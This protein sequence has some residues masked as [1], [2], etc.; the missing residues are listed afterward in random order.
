MFN[1]CDYVTQVGQGPHSVEHDS[2]LG[3][4][5]AEPV[6]LR[7]LYLRDLEALSDG[8]SP[9]DWKVPDHLVVL[10]SED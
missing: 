6:M 2:N 10:V 4:I 8:R 3:R 5:D 1:I 7:R 9:K